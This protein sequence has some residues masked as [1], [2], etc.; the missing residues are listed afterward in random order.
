[1]WKSWHEEGVDVIK[2]CGEHSKKWCA[3]W[4]D[5]EVKQYNRLRCIIDHIV[6][7]VGGNMDLV[8][9]TLKQTDGEKGGAKISTVY[10]RIKKIIKVES[11]LKH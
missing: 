11:P 1:L 3:K 2:K 8:S 5:S 10:T 9:A 4:D 7:Q 6:E